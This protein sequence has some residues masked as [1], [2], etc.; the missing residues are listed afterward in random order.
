MPP[1]IRLIVSATP[2]QFEE[3]QVP[4]GRGCVEIHPAQGACLRCV[5]ASP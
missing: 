2:R 1:L 5:A 3:P 4:L